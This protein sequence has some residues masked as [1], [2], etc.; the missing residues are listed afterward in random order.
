MTVRRVGRVT[1]WLDFF[2]PIA[3]LN[4][5]ATLAIFIDGGWIFCCTS[6]VHFGYTGAMLRFFAPQRRHVAPMGWN[7]A[8]KSPTEFQLHH[9]S[10]TNFFLPLFPS[11]PSFPCP[12]LSHPP[13]PFPFSSPPFSF[14]LLLSSF[15]F[16]LVMRVMLR[17]K[18]TS[19]P[20]ML[21]CS[22]PLLCPPIISKV[23]E[24]WKKIYQSPQPHN[25]VSAYD[26]M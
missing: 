14:R 19:R 4:F 7:L 21:V 15:P 1:S 5:S 25:Q 16:P 20:M 12:S 24:W 10:E 18:W 22:W 3:R 26:P 2:L 17:Y 11:L 6:T 9:S 13:V 8:W 23:G